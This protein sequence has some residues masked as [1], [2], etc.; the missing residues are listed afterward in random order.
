MKSNK[1]KHTNLQVMDKSLD[2]ILHQVVSVI[3]SRKVNSNAYDDNLA[4]TWASF[5]TEAENLQK[6]IS[7]VV[8]CIQI[9]DGE[10]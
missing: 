5:R 10:T 3:T 1:N 2:K 4:E 7:L 8:T 6:E 9:E